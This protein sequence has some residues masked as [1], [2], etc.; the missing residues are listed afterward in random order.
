LPVG[1]HDCFL[2]FGDGGGV[3]PEPGRVVV[4][5]VGQ[6]VEGEGEEV[7][8]RVIGHGDADGVH[9][10]HAGYAR[11]GE[12]GDLGGDPAA[13]GVAHDGDVAEVELVE[14]GDVEVG[15]SA[16]VGDVG[17]AECAVEAGVC[18]YEG[19]GRPVP[20]QVGR[21]RH[22]GGRAGAAV[23]Q[24]ERVAGA[25]LVDGEFHRRGRAG[26]GDGVRGLCG[27]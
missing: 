4:G 24:Q 6:L 3:E 5:Q 17:G 9:D 20:G 16:D 12:E 26:A 27:R 18:R 1:S 15:E 2:A 10:D 25:D 19:A 22:E 11:A 23:Q 13:D 7:R 14:Q 8:D 21:E